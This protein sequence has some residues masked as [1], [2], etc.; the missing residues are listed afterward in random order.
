VTDDEKCQDVLLSP[1]PRGPGGAI[2]TLVGLGHERRGYAGRLV[3]SRGHGIQAGYVRLATTRI[4]LNH[5]M[6]IRLS[7]CTLSRSSVQTAERWG[8]LPLWTRCVNHKFRTCA[9]RST[10]QSLLNTGVKNLLAVIRSVNR[11][12]RRPILDP[13]HA[14]IS[15]EEV[16]PTAMMHS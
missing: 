4:H 15:H 8:L 14:I 7:F 6:Q 1:C 2:I 11:P 10:G 5:P 3:Y 9:S 13:H 12:G 16:R